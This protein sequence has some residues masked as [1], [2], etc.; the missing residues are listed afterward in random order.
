M[1]LEEYMSNEA[2]YALRRTHYYQAGKDSNFIK[3]VQKMF[4]PDMMRMGFRFGSFLVCSYNPSNV[5]RSITRGVRFAD[6]TEKRYD[7]MVFLMEPEFTLEEKVAIRHLMRDLHPV[8]F[9]DAPLAP[10][11]SYSDEDR[12][13]REQLEPALS[14]ARE[15]SRAWI[16]KTADLSTASSTARTKLMTYYLRKSECRP[17]IVNCLVQFF[18]QDLP[19]GSVQN[20]QIIPEKVTDQIGGYRIELSLYVPAVLEQSV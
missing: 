20:Y 6:F 16:S 11:V 19:V 13:V 3:S 1:A 12:L 2:Y 18:A 9:Q 7:D 17:E 5:E 14:R 8:P 10:E 15:A 4:F